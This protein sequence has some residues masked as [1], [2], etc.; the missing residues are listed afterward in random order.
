MAT[1]YST[2]SLITIK[3]IFFSF[4]LL[5]A[6]SANSQQN[7]IETSSTVFKY[8]IEFKEKSNPNY[9]I[10]AP[11][12]FLSERALKRR[13]KYNIPVTES[14]IPVNPEFYMKLAQEPGVAVLS[15]SRWFNAV[16]IKCYDSNYAK[17]LL[18]N[19]N[20][21]SVTLMGAWENK[22]KN[23]GVIKISPGEAVENRNNLEKQL[24]TSEYYGQ[25]WHQTKMLNGNVLHELGFK[26]EGIQIAVLDA[27]FMNLDQIDYFDGLL[28]EGRVLGIKDFVKFDNSVFE[29]DNHGLNVI[30]CMAAEKPGSFVGTA[31]KASYYLLRSEDA[32]TEFP[33]EEFN[34]AVAA[35]YA[36]SC[37]ADVIN[38]SLGY[39]TF[40]IESLSH[41]TSNLNG[42]N[43]VSRAADFAESKGILV[44]NSAG[45]EGA[46]IWHYISSPADAKKVLAIG[47]VDKDE[48]IAWFSSRGPSFDKRV[49]PDVCSM[50]E[51]VSV[52]SPM[53]MVNEASG[54]SFAGPILCGMAACLIQAHPDK[55]PEEIRNAIRM[56]GD[57]SSKS[58]SIF[59][60]GLPDFNIAHLILSGFKTDTSFIFNK[61]WATETNPKVKFYIAPDSK[62]RIC[63]IKGKKKVLYDETFVGSNNFE[64][65]ILPKRIKQGNYILKFIPSKGKKYNG[66]FVVDKSGKYKFQ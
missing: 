16:L 48:D 65:W 11:Q 39:T 3:K 17:G 1:D 64:T 7:D 50:G 10:D 58:D 5:A 54:T 31:P 29:D 33:V 18:Q 57:R 35:E 13:A 41:K 26:G 59:G 45:N 63:I 15:T 38:S 37:G 25:A 42:T 30:S 8:S 23:S 32:E 21:K 28:N 34:W 14:D 49:K 44:I 27:G 4:F 52:V 19:P 66:K 2:G 53:G 20:V 6:F 12:F 56:S 9:S 46:N 36:D 51:N 61:N 40:D 43:L 60:H 22:L 55:T 47:A 62:V 24:E